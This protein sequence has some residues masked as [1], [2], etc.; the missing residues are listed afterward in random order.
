MRQEVLVQEIKTYRSNLFRVAKSILHTDADAEDAVGEC[1][2]SAFAHHVALKNEKSIRPWL[3]KI[4][5]R[6]SYRI[7]SLRGRIEYR[8]ELPDIPVEDRIEA[9]ELWSLVCMLPADHR[10]AI[11]LFYY[12]DMSIREIANTLSV[13]QGTVKARLSRGRQK[14]R[15]LL[16]EEGG[17]RNEPF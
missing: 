4:L 11:V 15:A 1:I 17:V 2:A 9:N 12:E 16:E 10:S 6:E 8:E 3:M 13:P 5:V 7:Q 14:L